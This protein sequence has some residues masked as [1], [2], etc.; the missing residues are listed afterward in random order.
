[1]HQAAA[2]I[3]AAAAEANLS[4]DRTSWNGRETFFAKLQP[5][6]CGLHSATSD[7]GYCRP[8]GRLLYHTPTLGSRAK[9]FLEAKK[10]KRNENQLS[11]LIFLSFLP[12]LQQ[13]L[14]FLSFSTKK[15]QTKCF[16]FSTMQ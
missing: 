5:N 7:G 4:K 10:E 15:L 3:V 12:F 6:R 13:I 11:A 2:V 1:M 9:N 16:V 14:P 8:T